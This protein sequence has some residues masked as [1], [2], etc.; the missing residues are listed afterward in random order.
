MA[1]ALLS[2]SQLVEKLGRKLRLLDGACIRFDLGN[3]DEVEQMGIIL[4]A[5]W[6][7][8]SSPSLMERL[9]FDSTLLD[10]TFECPPERIWSHGEVE[11]A[12]QRRAFWFGGNRTFAPAFLVKEDCDGRQVSF[13]EWW[14]GEVARDASGQSFSRKDIVLLV[15]NKE[16]AHVDGE[17]TVN[18]YDLRFNA[19]MPLVALEEDGSV[20]KASPVPFVIRHIAF[21]VLHSL[22]ENYDYDGS[23]HYQYGIAFASLRLSRRDTSVATE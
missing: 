5:L 19:I 16:A 15:A 17:L 10:A 18:Q 8:G 2:H 22:V 21:E 20:K 4:R 14:A 13:E 3:D 11:G 6:H 7:K 23:R 12:G 1:K 9:K